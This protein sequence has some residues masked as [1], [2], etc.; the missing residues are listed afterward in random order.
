MRRRC[1]SRMVMVVVGVTVMALVVVV[2]VVNPFFGY[3]G[4]ASGRQVH[5]VHK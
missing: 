3:F 4:P 5:F 1:E 2:V